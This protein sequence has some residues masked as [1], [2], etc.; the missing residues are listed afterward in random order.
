[1]SVATETIVQDVREAL[2]TLPSVR[3]V[4]LIGSRASGTAGPLSDWDFEVITDDFEGVARSIEGSLATLKPIAGQWDRLSPHECYMIIVPGPAKIDFLFLD[5]PHE[6]EPPWAVIAETLA[7]IDAHFWDWLVWIAAK[8][9][10]GKQDLVQAELR[11]MHE[12]VLAPMGIP[13][14]PT[15]VSRAAEDYAASRDRYER[16]FGVSVPRE[17]EIEIR[18]L[19]RRN[20]YE[21]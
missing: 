14:V 6:L 8:D 5:Q 15:D 2:G 7:G 16:E 13:S 12:H 3:E 18:G 1:M 4:R 11:K 10:A 17:L 20:G 9:S 21:L 19:L